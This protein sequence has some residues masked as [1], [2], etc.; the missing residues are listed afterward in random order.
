MKCCLCE[1]EEKSFNYVHSLQTITCMALSPDK[2]V[3]ATSS[4]DGDVKFWGFSFESKEA[5]E[6]DDGPS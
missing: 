4:V 3:L 2:R 6:D 1:I 5:D